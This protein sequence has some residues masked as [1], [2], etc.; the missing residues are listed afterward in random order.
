[1][2]NFQ[3]TYK[4]ILQAALDNP[5]GAAVMCN[6]GC[7][8]KVRQQ[9]Y[10]AR[11]LLREQDPEEN[12]LLDSLTISFSPQSKDILFIYPKGAK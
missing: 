11:R 9:L 2:N 5:F 12:I 4:E 3:D 1:M 8:E 10:I 7:A 6:P